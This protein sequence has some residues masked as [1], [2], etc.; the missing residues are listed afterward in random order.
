LPADVGSTISRDSLHGRRLVLYF[1]PQ[2]ETMGCTA[3]ARGMRDEFGAFRDLDVETFGVSPDSVDSH[4]A[5]RTKHALPFRLLWDSDHRVADAFGSMRRQDGRD[6]SEV[7][8]E[9]SE[10]RS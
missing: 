8:W 1:Y 3:Q 10:R 7:T 4:Q 5:F 2:D 9:M 6:R